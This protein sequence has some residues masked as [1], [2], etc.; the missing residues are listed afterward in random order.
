MDTASG[1]EMDLL[2]LLSQ[3]FKVP[4]NITTHSFNQLLPSFQDGDFDL[5]IGGITQTDSRSE[6]FDFSLP[7]Y[8][9]EQTVLARGDYTARIDSLDALIGQTIGVLNNSTSLLFLENTLI[10]ENR[11]P[12][13]NLRRFPDQFSLVYAL[14]SNEVN[15]ILLEK[16]VAELIT[17]HHVTKIVYTHDFEEKYGLVFKKKSPLLKPI[18]KALT[19]ILKSEEWEVVLNKWLYETPLR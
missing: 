19:D 10:K 12:T 16:T 3:R 14:L 6:L 11:I 1:L 13:S 18:N 7:Y 17:K 2:L 5:A 4:L 8:H 9:A 15:V